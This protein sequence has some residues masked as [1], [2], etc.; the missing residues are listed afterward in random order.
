[1]LDLIVKSDPSIINKL[2]ERIEKMATSL[3]H[4]NARV[5]ELAS[6]VTSLAS[7]I[8]DPGTVVTPTQI[9]TAVQPVID[10][11]NAIAQPP[12]PPAPPA[13]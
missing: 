4:L 12:A 6:A 7:R 11:V 3:E 10:Q 9:D 8:P 2:V 5:A 1:M 13:P